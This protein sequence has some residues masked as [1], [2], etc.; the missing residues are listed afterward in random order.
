MNTDRNVPK[1]SR[2]VDVRV[3]TEQMLSLA[4]SED[5]AEVGRHEISRI[6]LLEQYHAMPLSDRDAN[7]CRSILAE[8]LR[9]NQELESLCEQEKNAIAA[10]MKSLQNAKNASNAYTANQDY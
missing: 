8:I 9:L 4:R 2:L 3:L 5:W 7:E 1:V 6:K 10:Q